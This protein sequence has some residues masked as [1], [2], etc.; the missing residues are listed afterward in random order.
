MKL[1]IFLLMMI[2][3][4]AVFVVGIIYAVARMLG[5]VNFNTESKSWKNALERLRGHLRSQAAGMLVPWDE[6]MMSLLS[7]NQSVT[8]KPGWFDR[9]TEGVLSTIYQ[10]P[11]IAFASQTTGNTGLLMARTS[12][13]EFIFRMKGKETEVWVDG[14][15]FGIF[16]NG[17][18]LSAGRSS[19]ML[20]QLEAGKDEMQIP[21]R[22]GNTTAAAINNPH[23]TDAGPNPRAVTLLRPINAEEEIALL[24]VTLLQ[25]LKR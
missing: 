21:V 5:G 15:P 6:E 16:I 18:L 25:V 14:Q 3:F 20:A 13:K 2:V 1:L 10:E 7:I 22:L 17:T 24:A 23:R 19:S 8:K 12:K 9:S 11:V 4:P